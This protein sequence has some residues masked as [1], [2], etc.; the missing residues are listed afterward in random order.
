MKRLFL[1]LALLL[2]FATVQAQ[3]A[4][5]GIDVTHYAIHLNEVNFANRTL[6][7]ET[8]VDFTATA[9]V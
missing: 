7:G 8:F 5:E 6:Q 2:A 9:N 4:G 1:S 3:T